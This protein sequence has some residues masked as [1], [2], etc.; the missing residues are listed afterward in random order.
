MVEH[1]PDVPSTSG[2]HISDIWSHV[3]AFFVDRF[4]FNVRPVSAADKID[5]HEG[6]GDAQEQLVV[7]QEFKSYGGEKNYDEKGHIS[8]GSML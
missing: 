4:L 8:V 3:K 1:S 6:K 7:D 5:I 2:F